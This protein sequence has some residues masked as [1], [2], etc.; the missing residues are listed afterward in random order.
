[1][2]PGQQQL[3]CSRTTSGNSILPEVGN[4]MTAQRSNA[5]FLACRETFPLQASGDEWIARQGSHCRGYQNSY[6]IPT[7]ELPEQQAKPGN[8]KNL[9]D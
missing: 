5:S 6:H 2:N 8:K 9:N 3:V 4:L 7:T 1:M